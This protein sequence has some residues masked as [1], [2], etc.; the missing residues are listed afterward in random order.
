MSQ[1]TEYI[2]IGRRK[3][4]TARVRL[5]L[6]KGIFKVNGKELKD[7]F[8]RQVLIKDIMQ[9]IELTD[10]VKKFD[11]SA[12]ITGGGM[13]GQAGALRL[14][15]TRAIL[16]SDSSAKLSLKKAGLLTRD[17]RQKER[18]KYGQRGARARFQFSKR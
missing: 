5:V 18:K 11:I 4:A 17:P 16:K 1:V 12:N 8:P 13:T 9:P 15:I 14:G 7:Y 6:G 2:A 3:S 10:S